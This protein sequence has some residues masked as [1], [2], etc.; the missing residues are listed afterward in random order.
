SENCQGSGG[1][2]GQR[3][4]RTAPR[5]KLPSLAGKNGKSLRKIASRHGC[6]KRHPR[7]GGQDC[8]I[9]AILRRLWLPREPCNQLCPHRLCKLLVESASN[10]GVL[11]RPA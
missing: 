6:Q 3:S 5:T 10:P 4:R 2:Q 8:P 11:L 7:G 1:F 9:R